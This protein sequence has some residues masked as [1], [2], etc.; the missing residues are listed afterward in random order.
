MPRRRLPSATGTRRRD[1]A[2]GFEHAQDAEAGDLAGQLRLVPGERDEA[3]GREVVDLVGLDLLDDVDE[4]G[5]VEQVADRD[6]DVGQ[7]A[8]DDGA[9]S[10]CSGRG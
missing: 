8:L 7:R 2:D 1:D 9:A 5:L 3:D 4:G 10:G 6:L